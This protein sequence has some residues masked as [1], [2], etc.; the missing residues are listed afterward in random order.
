[1][2][3][4][5]RSGGAAVLARAVPVLVARCRL[6]AGAQLA[7][8]LRVTPGWYAR[9]LL[10]GGPA[11]AVPSLV[12]RC[13]LLAGAQLAGSV[14]IQLGWCARARL[15]GVAGCSK[16]NRC[17]GRGRWG[18]RAQLRSRPACP[19]KQRRRGGE[20]VRARGPHRPRPL[21]TNASVLPQPVSRLCRCGRR[22]GRLRPTWRRASG[23]GWRGSS[24]TGRR[25]WAA[26][27]TT[28]RRICPSGSP[29]GPRSS[30][31]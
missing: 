15:V 19:R 4:G 14:Q 5:D 22:F 27:W 9:A 1:V 8:S 10:G 13:R 2:V 11:R 30:S 31:A 20:H 21:A 26:G 12:S 24:R 3:A 7:G 29:R 18:P 16:S 28:R 25:R 17:W 6:L 23:P